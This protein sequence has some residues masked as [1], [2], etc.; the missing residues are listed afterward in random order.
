MDWRL[1]RC[2]LGRPGDGR[3][4]RHRSTVRNHSGVNR[5]RLQTT[6]QFAEI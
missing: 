1:A 4:R 6:Q 5:V 2:V 3:D